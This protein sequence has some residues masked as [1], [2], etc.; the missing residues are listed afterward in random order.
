VNAAPAMA[1]GALTPLGFFAV[2]QPAWILA[3]GLIAGLIRVLGYA[4]DHPCGDPV[5]TFVDDVIWDSTGGIRS[6]IRGLVVR[7][8]AFWNG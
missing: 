8:R 2:S 1:F 6:R 5:L 7:L 4:S 3:Y